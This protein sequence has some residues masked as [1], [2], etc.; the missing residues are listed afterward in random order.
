MKYSK[1]NKFLKINCLYCW[2]EISMVFNKQE[3]V[4]KMTYIKHFV[5][6]VEL[7]LILTSV[8]FFVTMLMIASASIIDFVL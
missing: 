6:E 4:N 1:K 8:L 7:V 3:G 5:D 2:H